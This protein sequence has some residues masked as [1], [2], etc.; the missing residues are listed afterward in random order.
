MH[1]QNGRWAPYSR[2]VHYYLQL[3]RTIPN[4]I[5]KRSTIVRF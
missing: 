1:F 4:C 3:I 2:V 5:G